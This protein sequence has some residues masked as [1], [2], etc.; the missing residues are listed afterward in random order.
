MKYAKKGNFGRIYY[1]IMANSFAQLW[2]CNLIVLHF[3]LQICI[4]TSF[5]LI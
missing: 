5:L 1:A 4:F 3:M 2:W